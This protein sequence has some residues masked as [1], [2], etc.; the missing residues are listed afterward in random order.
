MLRPAFLLGHLAAELAASCLAIAIMVASGL[1]VGWRIGSGPAEALAGFALLA[2]L[3][4]TMLWLGS[5]LGVLARSPDVVQGIG[6]LI[7]FPLTFIATTF[8]PIAGLPAGLRQFAEYNP[9]STWAAATRT[10]LGNPTATP[11]GAG[12]PLQHPVLCSVL[13]C[14][15][16][17]AVIVPVTLAAF[18]RRTTD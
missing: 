4:M 18:R 13:W 2:L 8:V 7:V 15:A 10:L 14:L 16:L 5:L 6:F 12:W 3:A 11:T 9:V 17:L 1:L